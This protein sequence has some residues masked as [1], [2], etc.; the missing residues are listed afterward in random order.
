MTGCAT[1]PPG[2]AVTLCGAFLRPPWLLR[3]A[4]F[5]A[6][7]VSAPPWLLRRLSHHTNR[8]TLDLPALSYLHEVLD[9]GRDAM[10][11]RECRARQDDQD[12]CR[13][14]PIGPALDRVDYGVQR[15]VDAHWSFGSPDG[16]E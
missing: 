3:R 12:R 5:C 6:V 7:M 9:D 16:A 15:E 11:G 10:D 1:E 14:R 2:S 8:T 13:H 4:G